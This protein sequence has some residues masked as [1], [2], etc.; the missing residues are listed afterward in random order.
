M[1]ASLISCLVLFASALSLAAA[2]RAELQAHWAFRPP[3]RPVV[4]LVRD[5]A[6]AQSPMDAFLRA[7]Q[8]SRGLTPAPPASKAALF[9]RVTLDLTG[10]PPAREELES[11]LADTADD[12]YE[13]AVD[14]LLESPR[15]GERWARHWMDVWRYSD[16]YGRRTVPDVMSSYPQIWRWRDWIISSLNHDK[17]YDRMIQEMLAADEVS[18]EDEESLAATGFIVRSWY[19]W[20]Y[21]IWM[22][23][24]VEHTGKAFLG[25]TLNC[26]HC[27]DHKYDP[28]T[29]EEYFKFRAFFEPLELRHDRVPELADPGPFKKYVYAE[30]YGPIASGRVR[31]FDEK[32]DAETF[33]YSGGDARNRIEGKPPVLPG[34]PASLGG[35]PLRLEP[36]EL[37]PSAFYPG[38][39]R[40]IQEE[41]VARLEE[42]AKTA[43]AGLLKAR[44]SLAALMERA[45]SAAGGAQAPGEK[46]LEAGGLSV[47]IMEAALS[48]ARADL[49]LARARVAADQARYLRPES[50]ATR[51]LS[52]EEG[53]SADDLARAASRAER[54]SRLR[55]AEEDLLKSEE[56]VRAAEK[57]GE[58]DAK[59]KEALSKAR[60]ARGK[61]QAAVEA[62]R[63]ACEGSSTDYSP[64]TPVYPSR[65]TGRRRALAGWI[66]SRENP[67]TAR[68]AVNHIWLRHFQAPLVESVYDFGRNGKKPWSQALLDWLAVELM[69]SGWSFKRI[70]RLMVTSS[71]YR[72]ASSAGLE[73]EANAAIDPDNRYLWRMN[74]WRLEAEAVRDGLLFPAGELDLSLGGPELDQKDGLTSR[75]RSLYYS[76]HGEGRMPFLEIFDAAN[77][78]DCYRRSASIVPQQ[79]LALANSSFSLSQARRLARK[80]WIEAAAAAGGESQ[81]LG[82]LPEGPLGRFIAAAFETV[83][84]R[85]P[86]GDE[87]RLTRQ[88]LER[89]ASLFRSSPPPAALPEETPPS[90]DPAMRAGESFVHALF[91]HNDF[92]TVR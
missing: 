27:H 54:V 14:R 78:C 40:F 36:V 77:P 41:T 17:G 48:R 52:Q 25:L 90:G 33:V 53:P 16:W 20:N 1:R 70:H 74:S 55:G 9:R 57:A 37:P 49:E 60:E 63:K 28:I 7:E 30:S 76:H 72:M 13:R 46:E 12:A 51:T 31:V 79:A 92:V 44:E 61:S 22:K 81:Q 56:A 18:P 59:S 5:A 10:L 38:L 2:D 73:G 34:V 42:A 11:F 4:P 68:V 45:R 88:F 39:K 47:R 87:T 67:L 15:H 58:A 86:S 19:K 83:L 89:Q 64:L 65:S 29:Q 84:S 35:P 3:V 69:D 26:A 71:A 8:E 91:N 32:L 62:T 85:E 82:A 23:D 43:A 24:L 75:R 50:A 6:W 80:L 66:A 21:N